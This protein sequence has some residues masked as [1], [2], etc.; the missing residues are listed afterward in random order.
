[1]IRPEKLKGHYCSDMT[2]ACRLTVR[3]ALILFLLYGT[4]SSTGEVVAGTSPTGDAL[5]Q[6]LQVLIAQKTE[7]LSDPAFL[8][9]LADIYLDLGDDVSMGTSDR[10]IAYEEGA[11]LARLALE[12][13]EQNAQAHYLY[14]A[15]LGSAAQL[16]GLMASA[17]S[18][19]DLKRH[20]KRAL[21]LNPDHAPALHMMGMMLDELPWLLGGDSDGALTYLRRAVVANAGDV[22]ARLDLARAYIKRKDPI[23]A[24]REIEII[25]LQP[26][27]S[28]F[29]TSDQRHREE[30]IQLRD[31][32]RS[33]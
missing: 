33:P 9:R 8:V 24:R 5:R 18:I 25:L 10:K 11:R 13:Q 4:S 31:S 12:L 28:D 27:P 6:Q 3:G 30:A 21:E 17:L 29:S 14:A 26:L 7:H 16:S 1:M 32:L 20:V 23:S 22:H 15:N 19:Q 2:L